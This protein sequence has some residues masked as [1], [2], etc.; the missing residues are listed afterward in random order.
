M[1]IDEFNSFYETIRQAQESF[2]RTKNI[3]GDNKKDNIEIKLEPLQLVQEKKNGEDGTNVTVVSLN[4]L[5][6]I[7]LHLQDASFAIIEEVD[8]HGR[9]REHIDAI[10][11]KDRDREIDISFHQNPLIEHEIDFSLCKSEILQEKSFLEMESDNNEEENL[12]LTDLLHSSNNDEN[13]NILGMEKSQVLERVKRKGSSQTKR[14]SSLRN[15]QL[16]KKRLLEEKKRHLTFLKSQ[17][18]TTTSYPTEK[19]RKKP[20]VKHD[21]QFI[22][23]LIQ[24]HIQMACSLCTFVGETF[25]DIVQHFTEQHS[26][27]KP[28]IM[29]CKRK[30]N[31]PYLITQHALKHENPDYFRCHECEKS[32]VDD[33]GLRAHNMYHH[34][35]EEEKIHACEFCS[36]RFARKLLLELHKATHIPQEERSIVCHQCPTKKTYVNYFKSSI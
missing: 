23:S 2:I 8:E 31:K 4:S 21:P 1:K 34:A 10:E 9:H 29:C 7:D 36:Q 30:L 32:F 35:A 11:A 15:K 13:S 17:S 20:R 12:L 16:L 3:L 6:N 25:T 5:Q 28:Y 24:K 26:L 33:S 19:R 18:G 14:L 22:R 27:D